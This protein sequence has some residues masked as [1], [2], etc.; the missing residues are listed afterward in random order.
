MGRIRSVSSHL[1]F[2]RVEFLVVT[3]GL[4]AV[5]SLMLN[6]QQNCG[7]DSNCSLFAT[8]FPAIASLHS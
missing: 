5:A 3:F 7:I 2:R 8:A 1:V 6:G 4:R